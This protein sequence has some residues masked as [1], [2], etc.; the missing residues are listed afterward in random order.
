VFAFFL[1]EG[2]QASISYSVGSQFLRIRRV[3]DLPVSR[4]LPRAGEG[5]P[6]PEAWSPSIF[7]VLDIMD[8][9]VY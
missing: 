5:T 4:K 8:R 2:G 1:C 6:P 3:I 7:F 9:M